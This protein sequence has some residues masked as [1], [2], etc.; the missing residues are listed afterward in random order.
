MAD[1]ELS[2]DARPLGSNRPAS[3]ALIIAT[4]LAVVAVLGGLAYLALGDDSSVPE[5]PPVT[6]EGVELT[7][8]A[9][10]QPFATDRAC[11]V[12]VVP[13]DNTSEADAAR[14]ARA[15]RRKAPVQTCVTPSFRLDS[16]A[17]DHRREQLD[18][19]SVADQLARAFQGA[20]GIA[21]ATVLGVTAFD[22]YSSTFADDE[23]DF[24]AAKQFRQ[25]KQGFAA[26]S[27]AR[28]GSDEE[29]FRR[30]ETMAM[31]YLGLLYFGLPESSDP[32]SALARS[33]RTVEELDLLEPRV[34]DPQPS[35]AELVAA[36][37]EVLSRK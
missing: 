33:I 4:A 27:T 37:E 7:L 9:T 8:G 3:T 23:F 34:A 13:V 36:R 20:R 5:I 18:A 12:Y 15:L 2:S 25:L 6:L 10:A 19:V 24:G 14:L 1:N 35:N 28:M 31:R 11:G 30:L 17:V 29:R 21:P 32:T 26:V 22:M 16:S